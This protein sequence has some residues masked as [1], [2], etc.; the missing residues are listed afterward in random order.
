MAKCQTCQGL[1][2]RY[3]YFKLRTDTGSVLTPPPLFDVQTVVC[4]DC[5]GTGIEHCCE[6]LREQPEKND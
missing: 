3:Q 6:G 1:G 4:S 5:G 2:R